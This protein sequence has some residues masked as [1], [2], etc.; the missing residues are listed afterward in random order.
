MDVLLHRRDDME[1]RFAEIIFPEQ[2]NH[3]GTLIGGHALRLMDLAAF[4]AASRQARCDVVTARA[5]NVDFLAPVFKGQLAEVVAR[6][7]AA[8]ERS[9]SVEV[10]LF[11]EDLHSG[12][13]RLCHRGTF[14]FVAVDAQGRPTSV[15][16]AARL[17]GA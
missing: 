9:M 16:E 4:V 8:S 3:Y 15:P 1:T 12:V 5:E 13:R 6:V 2:T 7:T 10:E 11:S 17:I 14:T